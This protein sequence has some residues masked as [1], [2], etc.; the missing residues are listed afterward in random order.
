M[1]TDAERLANWRQW[2]THAFNCQPNEPDEEMQAYIVE[3]MQA[4]INRA[5]QSAAPR[6]EESAMRH[7]SV[8]D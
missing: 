6:Y 8:K 3:E 2:A 4:R 7:V 1:G 5:L